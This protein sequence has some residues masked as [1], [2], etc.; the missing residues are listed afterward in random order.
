MLLIL[1]AKIILKVMM[2]HK[3]FN[4]IRNEIISWKSNGL[5]DQFLKAA[6]PKTLISKL[7]KSMHAKFNG[8][9]FHQEKYNAKVGESIVNIYIVYRLSRRAIDSSFVF[10][11]LF[12]WFK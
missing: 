7:V 1:E 12:V 8:G 10:K 11:K 2:V 9:L 5:S 6:D 4:L 3:Y